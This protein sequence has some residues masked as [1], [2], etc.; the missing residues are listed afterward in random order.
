MGNRILQ[1]MRFFVFMR[2]NVNG[3]MR[4]FARAATVHELLEEM[5]IDQGRVAVEVNLSVIRK[6][7]F[8]NFRLH[9]GD[10]VEVVNFVGGG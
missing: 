8:G 5:G 10:A 1:G 7:E 3:E 4:E 2:L 9:E 6:S